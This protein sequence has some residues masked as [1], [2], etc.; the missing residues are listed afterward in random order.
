MSLLVTTLS[1]AT[2]CLSF[3]SDAIT[4]RDVKLCLQDLEGV[5]WNDQI[6]VA[7]RTVLKDSEVLQNFDALPPLRMMLG[8]NGGKGG[9]GALLRTTK[10]KAGQRKMDNYSAC[11]DL[12]GRRLRHVEAEKQILEWKPTQVN[13]RD[14][15]AKFSKIRQ[16]TDRR[17]KEEFDVD[18]DEA[19]QRFVI[20]FRYNKGTLNQFKAVIPQEDRTF[21][22]FSQQWLVSIKAAPAMGELITQMNWTFSEQARLWIWGTSGP[23]SISRNRQ[24]FKLRNLR[25]GFTQIPT[26]GDQLETDMRDSVRSGLSMMKRKNTAQRLEAAKKLK[27]TQ[28]NDDDEED[29]DAEPTADPFAEYISL[30]P[31]TRRPPSPAAVAVLEPQPLPSISL[32]SSSFRSVSSPTNDITS[33][34]CSAATTVN[35]TSSSNSSANNIPTP[36][37]P[38]A[39]SPPAPVPVPSPP[40]PKDWP[41]ILLDHAKTATELKQYGLEHLKCELKR[42]GLKCGGSLEQRAERL[43]LL[44]NTSF[45]KLDKKHKA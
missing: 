8:L 26:N 39:L 32:S 25:R 15:Q 23:E 38:A 7:S 18:A 34:T 40:Q 22:K 19:S 36:S 44:K 17:R 33:N 11:R 42:R 14:L 24:H 45:D 12:N 5:P 35:E 27:V 43:F 29:D 4:V 41:P 21:V 3:S 9:F 28:E 30:K 2:R 10:A 37:F 6:L 13:H 1:G 20:T 16:G 31:R